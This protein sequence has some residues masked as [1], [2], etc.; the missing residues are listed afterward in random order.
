MLILVSRLLPEQGIHKLSEY[1]KVQLFSTSGITY[2]SIACHPDIFICQHE[3]G[4]IVAPNLPSGYREQ[5]EK[6]S[7]PVL[8][9]NNM[10]GMKYPETARFNAVITGKYLVHNLLHTDPVILDYCKAMTQIHVKQGYCSCNVVPIDGRHFITSDA[11]I[12]KVLKAMHLYS[13]YVDSRE[14]I[15]PGEKHGFIGGTCGI[16]GKRI[17]FAGSL[18]YIKDGTRIRELLDTLGF[19]IIELFRGRLLDLGRIVLIR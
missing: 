1:G 8:T 6:S 3:K 12:H 11:G 10:A 18:D 5:I 15:L 14:I 4:I 2:D 9:G 7:L 19:E 16:E 17:F 13:V